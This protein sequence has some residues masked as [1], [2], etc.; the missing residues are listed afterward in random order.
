MLSAEGYYVTEFVQETGL[1]GSCL[2]FPPQHM[3]A[4]LQARPSCFCEHLSQALGPHGSS[5]P[6][7][8]PGAA[9]YEAIPL[10]D[11]T[12]KD[13]LEGTSLSLIKGVT[14]LLL[15]PFNMAGP[16]LSSERGQNERCYR[17]QMVTTDAFMMGW[18]TVYKDRPASPSVG[19]SDQKS[20]A[21]SASRQDL[22]PSTR[23]LE[24]VGMA[25][26]R[27]PAFT[28][29]LPADVKEPVASARALSTR[30]LHSSKWKVFES[31][32]LAHAVD[33]VSCPVGPVLE[34]L[35]EKF[36][37]GA[38]ATTLRVYVVASPLGEIL[39]LKVERT[40]NFH[41]LPKTVKRRVYALKRLQLQSANI[42]AKFYE[43]VHELERKY[44]GLYQPIFDKRRDIVAGAVEPTDEECE[45]QSDREEEDLAEDLQKKA[46]L[47]EKQAD[48]AVADDPKGVPE[49][50]LTIFKR[51]DMLEEMLQV[52][53]LLCK[54]DWHKGK[55]VTVKIVKKKQK[56]KGRG[57]VRTVTKE[58][59]QDSFFN[60]FNP[61]KASPD[62]MDE[63]LDFTLAT[64]F[65]IGHFFRERVIP[66]AV[67]YFTGE[68][69]EDDESYEE[70]DLE[71]GEEEDLDDEGEE[72]D[73][74]DCD[75]TKDPP[76]AECKQQ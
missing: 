20:S 34:C 56:H 15:R 51:V 28:Y 3:L 26:K 75:P 17:R 42:E 57:T 36:A 37:V 6:G 18:G 67:L 58:V 32:C 25:H 1:S 12:F 43:E 53:L 33:P 76:P 71:E 49:F 54:I 63:D 50:W 60:F 46:A 69:L 29:S 27:P 8:A 7:A 62:G 13:P 45:W 74:G 4:P 2:D 11:E 10:V 66:K 73:E 9:S 22:T 31:W 19:D 24:A 64:D 41:L 70:E 52:A 44:A 40:L 61:V 38:V 65:E 21:I 48:S 55:D 72:E 47:E 23:D 35:Q 39:F 14:E 5:L 30:R 16:P 68:A 59:P